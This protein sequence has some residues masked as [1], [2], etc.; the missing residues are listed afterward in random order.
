M[1]LRKFQMLKIKNQAYKLNLKINKIFSFKMKTRIIYFFIFFAAILPLACQGMNS[2]NYKIDADVIGDGGQTG[3]SGNYK[4]TDT[5]GEEVIG[6]GE[7]ANYKS[8]AGFWHMVATTI[9]LVVDS[10]TVNLGTVT[11]G[12]PITGESALTV[13]TDAWGGY[14]LYVNQNHS[15]T[16]TDATTT[17][18]E[19]S[20]AISSPC[21]WSGTGLGFTVKSG[22]E[23]DAKWGSSPNY[24]YAY[25]PNTSTKFHE[26]SQ[27]ISGGNE[28]AIEYKLDVSSSQKSGDYSNIIT[29]VAMEKL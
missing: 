7:S 2:E 22:T 23:V 27:Y 6:I 15:M 20:C 17:I 24:K 25:F 26:T 18:P 11:P 4:L 19:Y 9:S 28:T 16:H 21:L 3:T 13:T 10:N 12:T 1:N 29:Y 14:E 5:I 8:K